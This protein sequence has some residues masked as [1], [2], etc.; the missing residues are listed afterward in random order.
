MAPIDPN[1]GAGANR[2]PRRIDVSLNMI[3]DQSLEVVRQLTAELGALHQFLATQNDPSAAARA[4]GMGTVAGRISA[5]TQG[6]GVSHGISPGA[7]TWD[8]PPPPVPQS[9]PSGPTAQQIGTDYRNY[10]TNIQAGIPAI[11]SAAVNNELGRRMS[12]LHLWRHVGMEHQAGA[13]DAMNNQSSATL[14]GGGSSWTQRMDRFFELRHQ[15]LM[16]EDQTYQQITGQ[17]RTAGRP[18]G[19]PGS[20][21]GGGGGR[22][23]VPPSGPSSPSGPGPD[24]D[25]PGWYTGLLRSGMNPDESVGMTIPRLGEFTIQD[26]LRF[27]SEY[28]G[29]RA[30]QNYDPNDP[31]AGATAGRVANVAEYARQQS[32]GIVALQ[33]EWS[34]ARGR[35]SNI[36]QSGTS[37]GFSPQG[38]GLSGDVSILGAGFRSPLATFT[39]DAAREGWHEQL[40]RR[41]LQLEPGISGDQAQEI[42]GQTAAMGYSGDLNAGIAMN[43]FGPLQ[44]QGIS[45]EIAAPLV[46]QNIRQGV[47]NLT[48][49]R[50]VII[51]LGTAA[52]AAHMTLQQATESTQEYVSTMQQMGARTLQ[53]TRDATVLTQAGIDPR[54]VSQALQNPFV[55]G[56]GVAMT[57]LPPQLLGNL[58]APVQAQIISQA[59]DQALA[60]SQP[61][62]QRGNAYV[63][64]ASGQKL[65]VSNA[66]DVQRGFASQITGLDPEFIARFQKNP[67]ILTDASTA[68]S[69][70]Q[71]FQD[72]FNKI[73]KPINAG[74]GTSPYGV[75]GAG[76]GGAGIRGGGGGGQ[77]AAT[78]VN[79]QKAQMKALEHGGADNTIQWN[80]VEAQLL[81]INPGDQD[82]RKKVLDLRGEDY[83]KR[84]ADANKLIANTTQTDAQKAPDYLVGLTDDAKKILKISTTSAADRSGA[85]T[86]SNSGGAPVAGSGVGPSYPATRTNPLTWSKTP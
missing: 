73:N 3:S 86:N 65:Q 57:G 71:T 27:V 45:P 21:G 26:K 50:D 51:Q 76:W 48:S 8:A 12:D 14:Y 82:W 17:G 58:G 31:S 63:T 43:V 40:T 33:R 67:N 44:Q 30:M 77:Y 69:A 78:Q 38:T 23:P 37:L 2:D 42:I 84:I 35:L 16:E 20:T 9:G 4:S 61:M 54:I 81:Q 64:L 24:G 75:K 36:R 60:L 34:K 55:Q 59:L 13:L 49:V 6:T 74:G 80:E 10:R 15:P 70:L 25:L 28:F 39:S 19:A 62:A 46:D 32:A 11:P 66:A 18:S 29:R 41:R 5:A 68:G 52:R 83:A 85:K 79:Q 1:T 53:A 7:Q 47:N 56:S 72:E 22:P